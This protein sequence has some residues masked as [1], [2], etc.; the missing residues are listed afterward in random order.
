MAD[1]LTPAQEATFS[2]VLNG[3][4][5]SE[6]QTMREQVDEID[7]STI[8]AQIAVNK[9]PAGSD[10]TSKAAALAAAKA[11]NLSARQALNQAVQKY[12]QIVGWVRTYSFGAMSPGF[13]GLGMEPITIAI[14]SIVGLVV[15]AAALEALAD[16][17]ATA[18]G[19]INSAKGY[20][21]QVSDVM[22]GTSSTVKSVAILV[23]VA[24]IA[25][26][27]I[28][29]WQGRKSSKSSKPEAL[30]VGTES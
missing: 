9:L 4:A 19:N 10:K 30:T 23:A 22:Y 1:Q 26:V 27:G 8:D 3:S 16:L 28:T 25:Y 6:L 17:I 13:A 20:I 15:V 5:L 24:A 7:Q 12:N 21:E 18:K 11:H 29:W 2:S 14:I